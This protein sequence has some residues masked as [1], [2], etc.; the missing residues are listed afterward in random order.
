VST[1]KLCDRCKKEITSRF[2]E[3][4]NDRMGANNRDVVWVKLNDSGDAWSQIPIKWYVPN[5]FDLCD[6]CATYALRTAAKT[7]LEQWE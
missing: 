3:S 7:I 6:E 5:D 4:T 2:N 1:R